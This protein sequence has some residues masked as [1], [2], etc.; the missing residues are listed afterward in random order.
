MIP[1]SCSVAVQRGGLSGSPNLHD[2]VG[3]PSGFGSMLPLSA[4]TL[5]VRSQDW[6]KGRRRRLDLSRG[7][8]CRPIRSQSNWSLFRGC[9]IF[10]STLDSLA[11][12]VWFATVP[13]HDRFAASQ[14]GAMRI[15]CQSRL[16]LAQGADDRLPLLHPSS[17]R[18]S[19]RG[20][21]A[22]LAEQSTISGRRCWPARVGSI[23][24]GSTSNHGRRRKR[25]DVG[26]AVA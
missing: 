2:C 16:V 7:R 19:S 26:E 15:T 18:V 1:S 17:E 24:T 8:G 9:P 25:T 4:T 22:Q 5:P 11:R 6:A 3:L 21:T 13:C 14:D 10:G 12:N 23:D 20:W